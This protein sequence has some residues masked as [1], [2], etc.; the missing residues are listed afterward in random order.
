MTQ[1]DVVL[2]RIQSARIEGLDLEVGK[3][4]DLVTMCSFPSVQRLLGERFRKSFSL[5]TF[6][7]PPF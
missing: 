3:E 2:V 4:V 1:K 6:L 5:T 7:S